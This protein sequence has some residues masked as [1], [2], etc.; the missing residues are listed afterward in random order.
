LHPFTKRN[1]LR[2]N[3]IPLVCT[4]SVSL[5][6]P[7]TDTSRK[8]ISSF[9]EL[10]TLATKLKNYDIL[11]DKEMDM[12]NKLFSYTVVILSLFTISW[13]MPR[14]SSKPRAIAHKFA[15]CSQPTVN[16]DRCAAQEAEILA[17]VVRIGFYADFQKGRQTDFHGS[18]SHATVMAGRYLVTHNHFSVDLLTL[19]PANSQGLT[20]Y[21]LYTA[22][23]E[24]IVHNAPVTAFQVSAQDSQTL[25]LDFGADYFNNLNIPSAS[26]IAAKDADLS[27]GTEVAQIDWDGER[28]YVVWT[29]VTQVINHPDSPHLELDHYAM[30]GA[31]GGGV[32][33]QS[34]HIA[35]NWA[36]GTTT[37]T[38]SGAFMQAYSLAALN[39]HSIV[40]VS[41]K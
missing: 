9:I 39:S 19:S 24:R 3:Y 18:T 30:M 23:G 21:S 32:F 1:N 27:I 6:V 20:G 26:F 38:G 25:V 12:P 5:I 10:S 35:N 4:N 11:L 2:Q 37:D 7:H 28:T 13:E 15:T 17:S 34:H 14:S 8:G 22:V 16:V 29:A 33:W 36:H 31:S 40:A 41:D